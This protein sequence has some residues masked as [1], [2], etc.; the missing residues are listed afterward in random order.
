M[1]NSYATDGFGRMDESL[2]SIN[3]SETNPWVP[4]IYEEPV[5]PTVETQTPESKDPLAQTLDMYFF[6]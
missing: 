3:L 1:K 4:R 6:E 2:R 5:K